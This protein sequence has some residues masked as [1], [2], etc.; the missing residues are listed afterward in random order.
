M[1]RTN[2]A[3]FKLAAS[4][5]ITGSSLVV[6]KIIAT[7]FPV[8]LASGLRLAIASAVLLP[9]LIKHENGIPRLSKKDWTILFLQAF[10]GV[11]LF[12]IALL[13][14]LR[15]TSATESGVITSTVPAIIALLSYLILKEKLSWHKG[16]GI[17]L[18]VFGILAI[19][20][21]GSSAG[22]RHGSNPLLGNALILGAVLG[23][24]LFITFGKI[25]SED[26]TPLAVATFVSIFGFL[27][28]MPFSILE[29]KGFNPSSVPFSGWIAVVYYVIIGTIGSIVLWQQGV[30]TV[31]ENTAA[32]FTTLM[33][34]SA[35]FL[36]YIVLK[37]PFSWYNLAGVLLVLLGIGFIAKEPLEGREVNAS[38][39]ASKLPLR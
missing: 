10:T 39:R 28:F 21:F 6:G 31:E 15:L 23:E 22:L 34:I 14:G 16:S 30:A 9:L 1:N 29:T 35:M 33:P 24:A 25:A 17:M 4:K 3:Y 2:K 26:V 8:F 37:E 38:F 7:S 12:S 5:V 20:I 19:N 13:Y 18:A 11:F 27:M 36:S 32:V